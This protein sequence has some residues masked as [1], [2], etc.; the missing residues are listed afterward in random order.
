MG[1]MMLPRSLSILSLSCCALGLLLGACRP[2]PRSHAPFAKASSSVKEQA[3]AAQEQGQT[4]AQ[5]AKDKAES[6]VRPPWSEMSDTQKLVYMKEV[7]TP[8][9]AASFQA[10]DPQEFAE[11]N[12]ATCHGPGASTG[13]FHM[14]TDALPKLGDFELEKQEHP[15]GMAF[16]MEQV[17]PQMAELLS[18]PR[19]DPSTQ[20]G[21][22]CFGCHLPKENAG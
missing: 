6:T 16:M 2:Q 10:H 1:E 3:A 20:K 14:P 19:F 17:V 13:N 4:A 21:F 15:K 7:V 5:E 11:F 22:G 9:M 12:C 18:M 8:K